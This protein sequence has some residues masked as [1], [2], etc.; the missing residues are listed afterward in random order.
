VFVNLS[1]YAG[2]RIKIVFTASDCTLGGH[3]GY[4]YVDIRG[5]E[6][7]LKAYNTCST[8]IRTILDGP[9]GFSNYSWYDA[10]YSTLLATGRYF[11]LNNPLAIGS[12][13]HLIYSINSSSAC[14]DTLHATVSNTSISWQAGPDKSMCRGGNVA[15]GAPGDPNLIYSWLPPGHLSSSNVGQVVAD[16]P[17][18]TRYIVTVT[19]T[20]TGCTLRDTVF[21]S[22]TSPP[23]IQVNDL[24]LCSGSSGILT[25]SG[26]DEFF[27]TTNPTLI[28]TGSN[29]A[30]VNPVVTTMY[31]VR[32]NMAGSSC[33][34][35]DTAIV[36]VIS[37]PD[38]SIIGPS[39][40]LICQG[41]SVLLTAQSTGGSSIQWYF[42]DPSD[43]G[44]AAIISGATGDSL[45][46]TA[47]GIYSI[48]LSIGSGC[49]DTAFHPV[50]ID[51]IPRPSPGFNFPLFCVDKPVN[52]QNTTDISLTG[53]LTYSWNFGD[54]SPSSSQVNPTHVYILPGTYTVT[55]TAY[56]TLCPSLFDSRSLFVTAE[57]PVPGIRYPD[58]YTARNSDRQLTARNI[59]NE[60]HWSPGTGLS[61]PNIINPRFNY[62]RDMEYLIRLITRA[63][64]ETIDT[65]RLFI[66]AAIDIR[67]PTAFTPNGDGHND[68]LDVF[69]IDIRE[70]KW[71]RV[72]NRWGQLLFETN[73]PRQ[74]WD[75]TF[76][77]VKQ[78]AE[79][80]VW[81]AEGV[82]IDG[83]DVLRRGQCV[84]LR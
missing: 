63:G 11:V 23:V 34:G 30:T 70:L 71:F 66:R 50:Q 56:S 17:N 60:Y 26:A 61:D 8:P 32:G 38:G 39:S 28:V 24:T 5:C 82:G 9:P 62:N 22:I 78:P 27:W 42:D 16:P 33:Y 7:S 77:G 3:W 76:K 57:A 6:T 81:I 54:N 73:D 58:I 72:F 51:F 53:P 41:E 74:L 20:A 14:V 83:S 52:F 15:I 21:V 48:V 40:S 59:A 36:T 10:N 49:E 65:Q 4:A 68:V 55:L 47:S 44:P 12:S 45:N 2:R 29:V 25:A 37:K 19:D 64:C 46:V 31:Y 84:L 1:R 69:L 67:V 80:Y 75:G 13:V 43:P 79:T 18:D 35:Y